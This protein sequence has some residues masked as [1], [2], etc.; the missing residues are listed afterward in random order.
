[1][2]SRTGAVKTSPSGMFRSPLQGITGMSLIENSSS[3][4]GAVIRTRSAASIRFDQRLLGLVHR[5][6]VGGADVEV[7][8]LERRGAHVRRL[9]ERV[10]RVA[11]HDPL[12]LRHADRRCG[13]CCH[14][15]CW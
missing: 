3:V 1:M 7:E 4:P 2:L 10:G 14:Q 13:P 15:C 11:Q 9:G 12:G 8:I 6:V 5:G